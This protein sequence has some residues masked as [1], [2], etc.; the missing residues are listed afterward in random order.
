MEQFAGKAGA[1]SF[2]ELKDWPGTGRTNLHRHNSNATPRGAVPYYPMR[3][4]KSG[5]TVGEIFSLEVKKEIENA[6]ACV[7]VL[8]SL[9]LPTNP[10]ELRQRLV[11]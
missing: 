6:F 9:G 7:E 8:K 5:E 1:Y 10:E 2:H 11:S 4:L 3:S